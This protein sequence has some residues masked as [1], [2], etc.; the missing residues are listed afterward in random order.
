MLEVNNIEVIYSKVILV[1]RGVSMTV[2]SGTNR[3]PAWSERGRKE[4]HAEGD[5]RNSGV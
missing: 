2:P 5:F 4:H 3:Q 1:L